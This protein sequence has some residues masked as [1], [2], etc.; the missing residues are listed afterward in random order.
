M[1]L[2]LTLIF[3]TMTMD[4]KRHPR[5]GAKETASTEQSSKPN[6]FAAPDFAFPKTV[7]ENAEKAMAEAK[8]TGNNI[9]MMRAAIQITIANNLISRE[10]VTKRIQLLDSLASAMPA[11]YNSLAQLLEAHLYKEIY[12][13]QSW[14]FD[15]RKL[16]MTPIPEDPKEWSGDMFK[17]KITALVKSATADLA[18]L[19]AYPITQIAPLLTGKVEDYGKAYPTVAAFVTEDALGLIE[20]YENKTY[21]IPFRSKADKSI[22]ADVAET[23]RKICDEMLALAQKDGNVPCIVNFIISRSDMIPAAQQYEYLLEQYEAYK[24]HAAA[25]RLL[26]L[27]AGIRQYI[28]T[29]AG[30]SNED[31][32]MARSKELCG[33][34]EEAI[35]AHSGTHEANHLASVLCNMKVQKVSFT[36]QDQYLSTD[37]I[38]VS[39]DVENINT[40]YIHLYR[41]PEDLDDFRYNVDRIIEEGTELCVIPAKVD[42]TAPFSGKANVVFPPQE[43]G[44]YAVIATST[45][46]TS[47]LLNG[48]D[49]DTSAMFRVSDMQILTSSDDNASEKLLYVVNGKDMSPMPGVTVKC[50][51]SQYGKKEQTYKATTNADGYASIPAGSW[52]IEL[53]HGKD[54]LPTSIYTSYYNGNRTSDD[55]AFA[56][57]LTDR[58]ICRPGDTV[59]FTAVVYSKTGR[60]VSLLPRQKVVMTLHDGN[61]TQ[62]DSLECVTDEHGRVSGKFEIPKSGVLGSWSVRASIEKTS[63]GSAYV[64]VAEYKTPSFY[65]EIDEIKDSYSLGDTVR[66]SGSVKTYSGMP[67][68]NASV[69]YDISYASWWL[70]D[71]DNNASYGD[72]TATD[73][74][75][76]F[77]VELPTD[78]LRGTRFCLGSYRLKVEATSPTGETQEGGSRLFSIGE[79]YR[80]DLSR[81][82]SRIAA[83]SDE[84]TLDV[85]VL[86]LIDKEVERE[87]EYT[88]KSQEGKI[89]AGT[90]RS[91]QLKLPSA[92]LPTGKYEL[93]FTVD[94]IKY[95]REAVIYRTT[96]DRAPYATPLWLPQDKVTAERGSKTVPVRVATGYPGSPILCEICNADSVI[97]RRWLN[98]GDKI[99]TIDVDAPAADNRVWVRFAGGHDLKTESQTVQVL[100]A[101][102]RNELKIKVE[103]FRDKIRPGSEEQWSFRMLYNGDNAARIPVMAVMTD[104]A[105]NALSP[106][107]WSLNPRGSVYFS[108]ASSIYTYGISDSSGYATFTDCEYVRYE[109]G[110]MPDWN[111]YGKSLYSGD[112]Y[113]EMRGF[114]SLAVPQASNIVV[115]E[116]RSL[117][118]E[119]FESAADE[120]LS[121]DEVVTVAYGA[122]SNMKK[123]SKSVKGNDGG[124]SETADV[125]GVELRDTEHPLA[126]FRPSLVTDDEGIVSLN[127]TVP[128]FNTTWQLQLAAY[129]SDLYSAVATYDA[130]SAKPVMVK[131]NMPRYLRT[132]DKTAVRATLMNNSDTEQQVAGVIEL[133]DPATGKVIKRQDFAAETMQP[134]SSRTISIDYDTP[135]DE[136]LVGIRCYAIGGDYTDGEQDIISILPS[137]SP[138]FE[139]TPFYLGTE[140]D[141]ISIELPKYDKDASVTLQYCDNPIWH[142]LTALP[143]ISTPKSESVLAK[144]SALFGNAFADGIARKYPQVRTAIQY[145]T[146]A[147]KTGADSTL[148]SNLQKDEHLKTVALENTVWVNDAAAETMRMQHLTSLLDPNANRQAVNTLIA[149]IKKAQKRD[150]GWSWMPDMESSVYITTGVL[151]NLAMISDMGYMPESESGNL[152]EMTSSAV[153]YIDKESYDSY[154]R[155]KKQIYPLEA[156][157]W[158][159]IRQYF[160]VKAENKNIAAY[161]DKSLKAVASSWRDFGIYDK[162]T[163]AILLHRSGYAKEASLILESLRQYAVISPERGMYYDNRS[164][165][166]QGFPR[167]ITTAQVLEAFAEIAPQDKSVD[168][169]RQWLIM[170]RQYGDWGYD[171]H[172]A[173]IIHAILASGSEWTAD[174]EPAEI[175]IGGEK[176]DATP[177]RYTGALTIQLDPAKVAGKTLH[178]TKHGSHPAW[179]GV[180]AQYIAPSEEVKAASTDQISIAKEIYALDNTASGTRLS[181]KDLKTGQKVRVVLT[182]K[183]A[184]DL[185]YVAITDERGACMEP[186]D[187]LSSY[188]QTDGTWVYR[189]TRNSQTNLFISFLP[190]GVHQISY[191]CYIDRDGDYTVGIATVQSLYAPLVTGHSAG[192]T[193]SVK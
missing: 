181:T 22:G 100:P 189:E 166:W 57:V 51:S 36:L 124:G 96:D 134:K 94:S 129:T 77:T 188:A 50:T 183:N 13:S 107:F 26:T 101:E 86:D 52:E 17:A 156:L 5:P 43:Y 25:L 167:L 172:T 192:K 118:L 170:Q 173:E 190:K 83:D 147:L 61:R 29:R 87:V 31:A 8:K 24:S 2:L 122:N 1:L 72:E 149:D 38:K 161:L 54:F 70:W 187:Q 102:S 113:S 119:A 68:S 62:R 103:S 160:G 179:G 46:D 145:W 34:I 10:D 169:L 85:P 174:S 27:A 144:A 82:P 3:P 157:R 58:S 28:Y 120:S 130:L 30:A 21:A 7:C 16:P 19:N 6:T 79:A 56:T 4:G 121:L 163:A 74:Q 91:P 59:G 39:V 78:E 140:A 60:N 37:S 148:I 73:E 90:F 110:V 159:Y 48:G 98:P 65:V 162:A 126:F 11:P 41:I 42:G 14:T 108:P 177:A 84:V 93:T 139:S 49:N 171:T 80:I 128:N 105:L 63:L 115:R 146:E 99:M 138:V 142:C 109:A 23:R 97:S 67:V 20:D 176:Y 193:V 95:T 137:S 32:V 186:V 71:D 55:R 44:R 178:V 151:L 180:L 143:E 111:L 89:T 88:I 117:D 133:F 12:S 141:D 45:R 132:G 66:I 153:K 112:S 106:F 116:S 33:I 165:G 76:R 158:L 75:G 92:S 185:Q 125:S 18:A 175:T 152:A 81:I 47:G 9:D 131:G 135:N 168:L 40:P 191:D 15:R 69:K 53:R 164:S 127:F 150:G 136:Q 154:I 155:N 182:V 184:S 64:D 114:R 35:A 104:K 123:K